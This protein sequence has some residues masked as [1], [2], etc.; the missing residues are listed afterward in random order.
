MFIHNINVK[1]LGN[2]KKEDARNV[3]VT[4]LNN[5]VSSAGKKALML[6]SSFGFNFY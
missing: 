5:E 2:H 6:N 4:N 3:D 1:I